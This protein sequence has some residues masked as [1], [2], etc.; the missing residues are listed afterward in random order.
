MVRLKWMWTSALCLLTMATSGLLALQSPRL[1][2]FLSVE[3]LSVSDQIAFFLPMEIN[4]RVFS[5]ALLNQASEE[6]QSL[7]K[8]VSNVLNGTYNCPD[9]NT[10]PTDTFYGGVAGITF[11][12]GS[13][14]ANA[15]VVFNSPFINHMIVSVLFA[16]NAN[17]VQPK[18]LHFNLDFTTINNIIETSV[19]PTTTTTTT[20]MP[21]STTTTT[22]TTTTTTTPTT[23]T[24][25][26]TT[27][28]TTTTTT[29]PTTTTTTTPTT[30]TTTTPTTTTT[31]TTTTPTTTTTTTTSMPTTTTTTTPT[32]TTTTTPTTTTTT[33]PTTTTRGVPRPGD[34]PRKNRAGF[35]AVNP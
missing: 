17:N 13:V 9:I 6:Y 23:T 24:T 16:D 1:H 8:E 21:T 28:P 25:T 22:P 14:I 2:D 4:N 33:T 7:Y 20:T 5:A 35:Y 10:C 11:R 29:T 31:T 34:T 19:P 30:T 3:K 15:T 12:S 26:T 27:T 32:T 18:T